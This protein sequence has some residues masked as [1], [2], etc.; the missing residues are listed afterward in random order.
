MEQIREYIELLNENK[1]FL[2]TV[3]VK[4]TDQ[5][6]LALRNNLFTEIKQDETVAFTGSMS[7]Y[8]REQEVKACLHRYLYLVAEP[9]LSSEEFAG[10]SFEEKE[11]RKMRLVN[12]LTEIYTFI[13]TSAEEGDRENPENVQ[14]RTI[15]R[16]RDIIVEEPLNR[17][18]KVA[19]GKI[20]TLTTLEDQKCKNIMVSNRKMHY[21]YMQQL[22]SLQEIEST[23]KNDNVFSNRDELLKTVE[24]LKKENNECAWDTFDSMSSMKKNIL[25]NELKESI[26]GWLDR[27]IRGEAP[28]IEKH[29]EHQKKIAK[30]RD[31]LKKNP[32]TTLLLEGEYP[33]RV[34]A[35]NKVFTNSL[36]LIEIKVKKFIGL[37]VGCVLPYLLIAFFMDNRKYIEMLDRWGLDFNK[38]N[39][40]SV[41]MAVLSVLGLIV[42][43]SIYFWKNCYCYGG[44][45]Q[46]YSKKEKKSYLDV[47]TAFSVLEAAIAMMFIS[48]II[49]D[50]YPR[51]LITPTE[52]SLIESRIEYKENIIKALNV[53]LKIN[54]GFYLIM[55]T[56]LHLLNGR[57]IFKL[58]YWKNYLTNTLY[59]FCWVAG[60]TLIA[61][62]CALEYYKV[63]VR[64]YKMDL[65]HLLSF[66]A[67]S[68]ILQDE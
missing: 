43:G 17:F 19:I 35:D 40:D 51:T 68:R 14:N 31:T 4:F 34:L 54:I 60:I 8:S 28:T 59:M 30:F 12:K 5:E 56:V 26:I 24:A 67:S 61:F 36:S 16:I 29:S 9:I 39:G 44:L 55:E 41:Y 27:L 49:F 10:M 21:L 15:A 50:I 47:V 20:T 6:Y 46:T 7:K 3:E 58:R 48:I 38:N 62:L 37:F 1:H 32:S 57:E 64:H 65:D 13:H 52:I 18:E 11:V 45:K 25:D 66:S 42:M 33:L 2:D 22:L 23:L 53:L 63:P